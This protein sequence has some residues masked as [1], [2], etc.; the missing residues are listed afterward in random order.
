VVVAVW[1]G[2]SSGFIN[3]APAA[4]SSHLFSSPEVLTIEV[5][6]S[7][8]DY[9]RL[10]VSPREWVKATVREGSTT[11]SNVALHVK[12][13][14]SF[15]PIDDRPS[16]SLDFN[17]FVPG[18]DLHGITRLMLNNSVQDLS[19]MGEM[20]GSE[21][22]R[23]AGVPAARVTQVLVK[24]NG[25]E[26]GIYLA[27]EGVSKRF[28]RHHFRNDQGNLYEGYLTD[29]DQPLDQD[30][31]SD[32][33][34]RDRMALYRA[35]RTS[36]RQLRLK[37]MEQVLDLDQFTSFLAVESLLAHWDG[38]GFHTNNY[39]LY[40]DPHTK[41]FAFIAHGMD[42]VLRRPHVSVYP[43]MRSIAASALLET[44]EGAVRYEKRLKELFATQFNVD[45][46]HR[47]IDRA[48][49]RLRAANVPSNQFN[50]I[51]S[52]SKR[53]KQ[54]IQLRHE[55]ISAELAGKKPTA[56]AFLPEG[57]HPLST[58]WRDEPDIGFPEFLQETNTTQKVLR[59]AAKEPETKA[60][61][62]MSVFLEHGN[63]LFEGR[64][65]T[66]GVSGGGACLR[67][68]GNQNVRRM[69]TSSE[70]TQLTHSFRVEEPGQDIEFICELRTSTGG[71]AWFDL[72]S[73]RLR[74][75]PS[76]RP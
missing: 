8:R 23:A 65:K 54:R 41:K 51:E 44:P 16:L 5:E 70:W 39:R 64:V 66:R 7:A 13:M 71:E 15:R 10:R 49:Q 69:A 48:L 4:R 24:L 32:T 43:P 45:E 12:G 53:L 22:F 68:S 2:W 11:R 29:I 9:Q 42:M 67:I 31:G 62:R 76:S 72:E 57:F 19:L 38:Y 25:R 21:M 37:S 20:L 61:W 52:Q 34:Q 74:K 60:A 27:I 3:G 36:D 6:L 17:R 30:N 18:Q 75:L 14:G 47:K 73:L 26:L 59:I 55:S 56:P 28:L 33:T 58:G 35:C 1:L 50:V 46:M 63:Y 40:H